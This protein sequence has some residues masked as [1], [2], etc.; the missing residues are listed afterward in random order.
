MES[1]QTSCSVWS[2]LLFVI[3]MLSVEC[4]AYQPFPVEEAIPGIETRGG[5]AAMLSLRFSAP[6]VLRYHPPPSGFLKPHEVAQGH[7]QL[8]GRLELERPLPSISSL[9]DFSRG[10]HITAAR[11]GL[12]NELT[13]GIEHRFKSLLQ[14]RFGF[15]DDT[16]E[17]EEKNESSKSRTARMNE[18]REEPE[19]LS[20]ASELPPSSST[21]SLPPNDANVQSYGIKAP[22][23]AE[24]SD[25]SKVTT[26]AAGQHR[27]GIFTEP[28]VGVNV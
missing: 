20:Y 11:E 10:S 4:Q 25:I 7:R 6:P 14:Q 3:T 5:L 27:L 18:R 9:R 22:L 1:S 15:A 12:A 13:P 8:S 17:L 16:S 19:L 26:N 2:C 28:F 21:A 24:F 23:P